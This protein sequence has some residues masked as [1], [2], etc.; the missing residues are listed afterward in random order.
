M[1]LRCE[2][3]TLVLFAEVYHA[4]A[5]AAQLAQ[6]VEGHGRGVL[7]VDD[8]L[9]HIREAFVGGHRGGLYLDE[10][11]SLSHKPILLKLLR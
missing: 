10:F 11:V 6:G 3:G 1:G 4:V 2:S 7:P 8:N 9:E 5:E